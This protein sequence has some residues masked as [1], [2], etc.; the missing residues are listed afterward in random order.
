[1]R[2]W[3]PPAR[4]EGSV[5]PGAGVLVTNLGTPDAPTP[6]ALRRYLREFLGD[7]RVVEA[8]RLV[9]RAVLNLIVLPFRPR[10]SAALY[11]SIWTDEGSPL[12]VTSRR[13]ARGLAERLERSFGHSLPVALGM[14]YGNPSI[15]S[16]LRELAEKGCDRILVLPLYPQYSG[17]TTGST[18]DALG[19][20]L[21]VWRSV[22]A[23]RTVRSYAG[24][25][26]YIAALA[27]SVREHWERHGRGERLLMS[28]HGIPQR[29][30]REGDPYP[31]ECRATADALAAK[32]GLEPEGWIMTFQSRFGPEPWLQPYTDETLVE[33]GRA[34]IGPVDTICP[35]FSAD[36]LETLEEVAVTN[37]ELYEEA[38][39]EGYR[40]IPALNDRSDHL[41]ALAAIAFRHLKEWMS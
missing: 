20:E 18:A 14:R 3:S 24:D 6:G 13:Q 39:G 32:L 27:A 41:D 33:W 19:A 37:R 11:R 28:F 4:R 31:L 40:Y 5:P 9:W 12:L 26:G 23:L 30:A 25:P 1:M 29:Y 16:A 10:R 7:P 38:G 8:P 22:P 17:S 21:A 15:R 34:G 2:Y 35:G 36:C